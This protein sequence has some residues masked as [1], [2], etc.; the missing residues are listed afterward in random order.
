MV[1][2]NIPNDTF[3]NHCNMDTIHKKDD[4]NVLIF[5]KCFIF[6]ITIYTQ[7]NFNSQ[8]VFKHYCSKIGNEFL[9]SNNSL[10]N[11]AIS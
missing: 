3:I 9:N 7:V 11:Y 2:R 5:S 1:K 10:I 4:H 6:I 8:R